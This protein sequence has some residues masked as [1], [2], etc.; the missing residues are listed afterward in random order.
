MDGGID[1]KKKQTVK[2]AAFLIGAILYTLA[3]CIKQTDTL[4]VSEK[5]E[6]AQEPQKEEGIQGEKKGMLANAKEVRQQ[7]DVPETY[8]LEIRSE[9]ITIM[10]NVNVETP[11]KGRIPVVEVQYLSYTEEELEKIKELLKEE[12]G[13]TEWSLKSQDNPETYMSP[14]QTYTLSLAKGNK[15]E[16]PMVWLSCPGISDSSNKEDGA[17]DLS[18]FSMSENDRKAF[19]QEMEGKANHLM[20]EMGMKDFHLEEVRWRQL[21]VSKDYSWSPSGKYGLR[22]YYRRWVED[23]ILVHSEWGYPAQYVEF[24][25]KEDGTLLSVKNIGREELRVTSEYAEFLLPFS[26]VSQ[27]FEQCMKTRPID[28][29][30]DVK[31]DISVLTEGYPGAVPH[32]YL[33][34]TEVKLAYGLEY[35]EAG[36]GT[37]KLVPVWAFYGREERGFQDQNGVELAI[38]RTSLNGDKS[39]LLLVVNAQNGSVYGDNIM[40]KHSFRFRHF[41]P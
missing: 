6:G 26:S 24:L 32:G 39:E 30:T 12:V 17:M 33:T 22:L 36:G 31:S 5:M 23:M 4:I 35:E 34:I 13:I 3:G 7:A 38:P 16:L 14:D 1:L 19:Q 37:G 10:G 8:T 29:E 28:P 40:D 2:R 15:Q 27:V 9:D 25:Y 20:E 21:S 18:G 41:Y 11:K